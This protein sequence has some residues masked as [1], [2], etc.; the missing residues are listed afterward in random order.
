ME[1]K[2]VLNVQNLQQ[3]PQIGQIESK[4]TTMVKIF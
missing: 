3:R 1:Q 2:I 4:K